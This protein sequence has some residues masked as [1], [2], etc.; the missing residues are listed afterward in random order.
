LGRAVPFGYNLVFLTLPY[1]AVIMNMGL[2]AKDTFG[3]LTP[4][5]KQAST[6]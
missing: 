3:F 5:L 4:T 1:A 6:S 2:L